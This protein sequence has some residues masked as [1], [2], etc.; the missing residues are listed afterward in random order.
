MAMPT[1]TAVQAVPQE[2]QNALEIASARHKH[3]CPRRSSAPAA[4]A[5]QKFWN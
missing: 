4:H 5:A 1:D 2:L 3:L